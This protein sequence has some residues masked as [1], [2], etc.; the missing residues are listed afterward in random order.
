MRFACP[1]LFNVKPSAWY[2]S[3]KW[4]FPEMADEQKC[5]LE[6]STKYSEERMVPQERK[7]EWNDIMSALLATR[8]PKTGTKLTEAEIWGEAHLMIAAGGD[9]TSTVL[10]SVLFYLFRSPTAY[11]RLSDEIRTI[12]PTIEAIRKG[13]SSTPAAISAPALT[14]R[15]G[16]HLRLRELSGAKSA[17][18]ARG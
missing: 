17:L 6:I 8:D 7:S 5:F 18:V 3:D 15:W 12:F 2:N 11:A 10:A 4:I 9:I 1:A 13:T 16:S 14:K